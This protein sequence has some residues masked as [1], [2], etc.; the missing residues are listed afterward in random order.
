MHIVLLGP[1]GSGKGT[2]A[3]I[4]AKTYGIPHISTGDIL[5]AAMK[6]ATPLGAKAK[7]FV[8]RGE[9][10]PDEVVIGIVRERVAE[11]DCRKGFIFDGFPRTTPQADALAE[12]LRDQGLALDAVV[13]IEVARTI[14]M[15]RM[16]GRRVCKSCGATYHVALNPPRQAGI[17][18]VCGGELYQRA[19]DN[20]EAIR[21]R[22]EAYDQQ[23]T[24]LIE[25]YQQRGLL[26][27]IDGLG[28][29]DAVAAR[30][31]AAVRSKESNA[32]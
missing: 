4:L 25:Y 19:D 30:L 29:I 18:D 9:L 15:D 21:T 17:C 28:P 24:P 20:P 12:V 22:L 6:A 2:Q 3:E 7:S 1:Q 13:L 31:T 26:A 10:V 14:L 16:T 11:P 5:R 32:R 27:E 8:D 23:T